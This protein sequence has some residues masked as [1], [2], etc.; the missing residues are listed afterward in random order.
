[1]SSSNIN[2]L[3]KD[4]RELEDSSYVYNPIHDNHIINNNKDIGGSNSGSGSSS[5]Y[6]NNNNNNNNNGGTGVNIA[7]NNNNTSKRVSLFQTVPDQPM[8]Y[9]D[10][11]IPA[12]TNALEAK[13][14]IQNHMFGFRPFKSKISKKRLEDRSPEVRRLYTE[15]PVIEQGVNSIG[16]YVYTIFFGV[17]LYL[18]YALVSI[19]L[20]ITYFGVPY[21][22]ITWTLKDFVLWPFG[23]YLQKTLYSS[24]LNNDSEKQ[25]LKAKPS[26][27]PPP[28]ISLKIGAVLFYIIAAPIIIIFE[29]FAMMMSWFVVVMIPTSKMHLRI[30]KNLLSDPLSLRVEQHI[31]R[32]DCIIL[33]YPVE[34]I[35]FQY[36]KFSINGM[37][38][39]LVN[40]LPFVVLSLIFGFFLEHHIHPLVIFLCCVLSTV[41]L[42]YYNCKAIATLSAQTSFAVGALINASFGSI[43]ELILYVVSLSNGQVEVARSAV[44]GS[45]LGAML[46]VPGLAMVVGGIKH[47][48][49]RFNH[50]VMGV[51]TVLLM[52]AI[53]G[54]FAPTILYKTYGNY[55]LNCSQCSDIVGNVTCSVC[56]Y[57]Q[58]D[59]QDDPVW[60][61]K[62]R[63]V[64][65]AVSAVLP[66]AY[67]IGLLFTL[68]THTHILHVDEKKGEAGGSSHGHSHGGDAESEGESEWS[69]SQCIVILCVCTTM[70]ALISEKLVDTI[71]PVVTTFHLTPEFLG[72]TILGIVPTAAEYLNAVQFALHNNMPLA[73]EIG[74]C[75]S[76]QITLFQIPV[77]VFISAIMSQFTG[78]GSFNLIF[79]IIDFY[80]V[81][82]GAVIMNLVFANG[83]TNYFIG[84]TLCIVYLIIVFV[85]FFTPS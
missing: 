29:G 65:Y 79:P 46:L 72:I 76:V 58:N 64:Q 62:A 48:E 25:P 84:S 22:K 37:N 60:T 82:L 10:L 30:L 52:V 83:K 9:E 34:A 15:N 35:N 16:N 51:N 44:T 69:R 6:N 54:I 26:H 61:Q 50:T 73:L 75:G 39:C 66:I 41:P 55:Q 4:E 81:F 2:L 70:F 28:S 12:G 74:A 78:H 3:S 38:V 33:A 32:T 20:F 14:M 80:A 77:L 67:F 71:D 59:I 63:A 13:H 19:L 47:K 36:Y 45:L 57:V 31:P 68:K 43:I 56:E 1:M 18:V 49:Q 7:T 40:L 23:R 27:S 21:A 53:V 42:S 11:G 5:N 85:F 24:R 17:I 8:T